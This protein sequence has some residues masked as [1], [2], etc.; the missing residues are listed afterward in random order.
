MK[1][2]DQLDGGKLIRKQTS[3]FTNL[4]TPEKGDFPQNNRNIGD[5]QKYDNINAIN[6]N[7]IKDIPTNYNG[8]I[9]V[10]PSVVNKIDLNLYDLIDSKENLTINGEKIPRRYIIKRKNH[11]QSRAENLSDKIFEK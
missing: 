8:M 9:G 5:Y 7:F 3:W 1:F 10:P 2:S 4:D 6:V 11:Q